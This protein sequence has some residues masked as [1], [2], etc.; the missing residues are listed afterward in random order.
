VRLPEKNRSTRCVILRYCE[1]DN[2]P[3]LILTTESQGKLSYEL[4][5]ALVTIGRA[6]DNMVIID[7]PSVSSRHA[8]LELSGELYRLKD[9][10]ST[11]GTRVNGLPITETVLRFDDRIRFGGVEARFEPDARGSQP[12]PALKQIEAKPA[13]T[14]A[15]PVDFANASPFPRRRKDRDRARSAI[16]ALAAVAILIFLGSMIAVLTMRAPNL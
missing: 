9:L 6:L 7:D 14:S 3:K 10:D 12:L 8:Q 16:V 4:T 13:E 2:M 1:I 11:N 15:A 5:E